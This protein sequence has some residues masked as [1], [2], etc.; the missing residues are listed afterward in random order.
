MWRDVRHPVVFV[1]P[2]ATLF[3]RGWIT[4]TIV[5]RVRQSR[6]RVIYVLAGVGGFVVLLLDVFCVLAFRRVFEITV[7]F[8]VALALRS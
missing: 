4:R 7:T 3:L 8:S 5:L 2:R 1:L 6:V